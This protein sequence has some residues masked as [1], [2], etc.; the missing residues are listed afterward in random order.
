MKKLVSIVCFIAFIFV[1]S[2]KATAAESRWFY[3][4]TSATTNLYYDAK[5]QEFL[6]G[7]V[8]K[9]WLKF[10]YKK[11]DPKYHIKEYKI[12]AEL[13]CYEERYRNIYILILKDDNTISSNTPTEGWKPISPDS[14]NEHLYDAI[15]DEPVP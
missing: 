6:E 9:V 13:D 2:P 4:A 3:Y 1:L 15:C 11:I 12:L 5:S 14:N 10:V 8:V 7:D